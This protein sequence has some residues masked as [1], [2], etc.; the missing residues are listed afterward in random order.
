[1]AESRRSLRC[2]KESILDAVSS[3]SLLSH[4]FAGLRVYTTAGRERVVRGMREER[5]P[6]AIIVQV[7]VPF[8]EAVVSSSQH[9]LPWAFYFER[10]P[11]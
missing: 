6:Y 4:R 2:R 3:A 8:L 11:P 10:L 1:M 5:I 7:L 9:N